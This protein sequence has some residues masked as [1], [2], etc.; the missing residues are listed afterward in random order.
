VHDYFTRAIIFKVTVKD[1]STDKQKLTTPV[2]KGRAISVEQFMASI[3][4]L[5]TE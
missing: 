4:L 5:E 1:S 2:L 3:F